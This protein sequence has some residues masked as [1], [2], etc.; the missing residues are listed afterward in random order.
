[1]VSN[2]PSS[3]QLGKSVS[4]APCSPSFSIEKVCGQKAEGLADLEDRDKAQKPSAIALSESVYLPAGLRGLHPVSQ[5]PLPSRDVHTVPFTL[6]V[7]TPRVP[8]VGHRH[9]QSLGQKEDFDPPI[10]LEGVVNDLAK[11]LPLA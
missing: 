1:M 5:T 10:I 8:G 2:R 3:A 4:L 7:P 11:G 6:D 9:V